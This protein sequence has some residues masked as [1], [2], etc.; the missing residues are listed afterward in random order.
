MLHLV[1]YLYNWQMGFNS[2]FK[3]LSTA[4]CSLITTLVRY[5][6]VLPN[7]YHSLGFHCNEVLFHLSIKGASEQVDENLKNLATN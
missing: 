1:G 3:G 2:V 4:P 6:L 7:Y 5:R